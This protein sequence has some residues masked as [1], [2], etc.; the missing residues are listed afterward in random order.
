MSCSEAS[1][2][3]NEGVAPLRL[4]LDEAVRLAIEHHR[5]GRLAHAAR[6]YEA[7]LAAKADEFD[8]LHLLGV[9]RHQQGQHRDAVRLIERALAVNPRSPEALLNLGTAFEALGRPQDALDCYDRALALRPDFPEALNNRGGALQALKR[10]DEALASC[11]RALAL[12]SDNCEALN[13]RGVVLHALERHDEAIASL[14]RAL[15]LRPD[16]PDA[17]FNRGQ[18]LHRLKRYADALDSFDRALA[19]KPDFVAALND[20][21]TVLHALKR[22]SEALA[23]LD[24]AL[25]VA[26]DY[27]DAHF[28]RGQ[29]LQGLKR[30]TEALASF[31]K[32]LAIRPEFAAALNDRA[33][34]LHAL[35][36]HEEALAS[37]DRAL[38]LEPGFAK[39]WSNRAEALL[40]L[41]RWDDALSCYADGLARAPDSADLRWNDA[42]ARLLLGD[43]ERGWQGYEWRWK[44]EKSTPPP[45]Y[46][47]GPLW[48]GKE[49]LAG[50][51]ILLWAEQGYGDTI[52][53]VR[54]VPLVARRGATVL[55]HVPSALE[56]LIRSIAGASC[57]T[58]RHADL[59]AFDCHC[60]LPSL[61]LALGTRLETIPAD[62]PYLAPTASHVARW[63]QRI[64]DGPGLRVG[65]VWAGN[66]ARIR[67]EERSIPFAT[68]G[69]LLSVPDIRFFSLQKDM[70]STDAAALASTAVALGGDLADFADT[71]AIASLMDLVISV[72]TSVVHV[73]GALGKPVWILIEAL[74]D[75]RWLL[76]RDDSPWYP[77]ARLFRQPREGDWESVIEYVRHE[78]VRLLTTAGGQV[79]QTRDAASGGHPLR[80]AA[81]GS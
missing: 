42:C 7:I 20:R 53:F 43:Y 51:T 74:P 67:D 45:R 41:G 39:A 36:R 26:P 2:A 55:L 4:S 61:P 34:A 79:P 64:G 33:R 65:L 3:A 63:R 78:L 46:A 47:S 11:D 77:S 22:D 29:A 17:H 16:L 69:A 81:S 60:P 35:K 73:A 37:A 62:I 24:R 59:T 71:A 68:F 48:L 66:P 23:T 44:L 13:N 30:Y 6:A 21:G 58:S 9:V 12:R 40:S 32:A 72:D 56:P 18:A 28:N 10:F 70:R 15:A 31:D 5:A 19:L 49:S 25:A 1:P 75:F 52:Q 76:D 57:V 50:K 54:Y 80:I 38:A 14:D 27:A 8:A